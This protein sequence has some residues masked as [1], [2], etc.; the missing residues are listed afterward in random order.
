[1][2]CSTSFLIQSRVTCLGVALS[3][4]GRA[5]PPQLLIM[6]MLISFPIGQSVGSKFFNWHSLFLGGYSCTK[7][8]EMYQH[9]WTFLGQEKK[10]A[11]YHESVVTSST[12]YWQTTGMRIPKSCYLRLW[13]TLTQ[14]RCGKRYLAKS[15]L[16]PPYC[17]PGTFERM[18]CWWEPP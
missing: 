17:F 1:M 7:I 9:T 13:E 18:V 12:F 5:L 14:E 2:P 16:S 4:V 8:T 6:K 11:I 10:Q 15:T 3:A